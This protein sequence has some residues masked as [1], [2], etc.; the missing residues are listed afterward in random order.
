MIKKIREVTFF[1]LSFFM[2]GC[3]NIGQEFIDITYVNNTDKKI[4]VMDQWQVVSDTSLWKTAWY[5]GIDEKIYCVINPRNSRVSRYIKKHIQTMLD[6]Y[7]AYR[8]VFYDVDTLCDVPWERIE[9]EYIIVK[10]VDVYSLDDLQKNNYMIT[11][12]P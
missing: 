11:I 8:F 3:N 2:M 10:R 1:I 9:K 7:G 6:E 12:N 5:E 4:F